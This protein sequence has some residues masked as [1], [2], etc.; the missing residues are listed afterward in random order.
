M[1]VY[2]RLTG[3]A[4]AAADAGPMPV[5]DA[6]RRL[7]VERTL[8]AVMLVEAQPAPELLALPPELRAAVRLLP[9]DLGK[10]AARA[11]VEDYL[12]MT[13]HGASYPGWMAQDT[14]ALA[15]MTFLV[16]RGGMRDEETVARFAQA[17]C[18]VLPALRASGHRKWR[19]VQPGFALPNAWVIWPPA[20]AAFQACEARSDS[21]VAFA[22]ARAQP[23]GAG[24]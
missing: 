13:I 24:R 22:G 6:I 10:S 8:D 9:V 19:E 4:P 16:A 20:A 3:V 23:T 12:P 5:A 21:G 14:P 17:L 18:R 7:A 15:T 2:E 1:R 11:A